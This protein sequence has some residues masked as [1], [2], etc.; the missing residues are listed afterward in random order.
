MP[1]DLY[2]QKPMQAGTQIQQRATQY[3]Q[4]LF[5][6]MAPNVGA[7]ATPQIQIDQARLQEAV[8]AWGSDIVKNWNQASG[9]LM[10]ALQQDLKSMREEASRARMENDME[11]YQMALQKS[12][13]DK[14]MLAYGKLLDK[15]NRHNLLNAILYGAGQ[16]GAGI[17]GNIYEKKYQSKLEKE[18]ER[19]RGQYGQ[20]SDLLEYLLKPGSQ[21]E[22]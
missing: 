10:D 16:V 5:G 20:F 15:A 17:A 21:M 2:G 9:Q 22:K 11:R 6:S 4:G 13:F 18:L 12:L 19:I 3:G 14:Q 7:A 1:I 8:D